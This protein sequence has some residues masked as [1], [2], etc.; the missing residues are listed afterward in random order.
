MKNIFF[1]FFISM[2]AIGANAQFS[3]K[4]SVNYFNPCSENAGNFGFINANI[5]G[6]SNEI[7]KRAAAH[8]RKQFP[9]VN[10]AYWYKTSDGGYIASFRE[11]SVETKVAYNN[12]GRLHHTISYYGESDLS[13]NVWETVKSAY[14]AYNILKIAEININDKTVYMVYMQDETR[15]KTVR[16]SDGE[17][18]EVQSFIKG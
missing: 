11:N 10:N 2:I 16:V 6:I 18:E 14:Y 5:N 12:H 1:A 13:R 3:F 17:V 15:L 9:N 4:T 7:D 8:F